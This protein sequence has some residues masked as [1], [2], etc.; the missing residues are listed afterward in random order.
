M[1]ELLVSLII[2]SLVAIAVTMI[3]GMMLK[4][5]ADNEK[6][7]NAIR[8]VQNSGMYVTQDIQSAQTIILG[9]GHFLETKWVDWDAVQHD[10]TYD[11]ANGKLARSNVI[12]GN[13]PVVTTVGNYI[14][15]S[16]T[17]TPPK[18]KTRIEQSGSVYNLTVTAT[19]SGFTANGLPVTETRTY[20][21]LPRS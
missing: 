3:F 1:I 7:V 5:N 10:V 9:G 18:A 6:R 17:G 21:I 13:D 20:E 11:I 8:Q 19:I 2:A 12:G 4:V 16:P 14:D 15:T